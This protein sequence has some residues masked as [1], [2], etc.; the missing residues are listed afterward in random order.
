MSMWSTRKKPMRL[1]RPKM[2]IRF[3]FLTG[4]VSLFSI[5]HDLIATRSCCISHITWQT[6]IMIIS[7]FINCNIF[8]IIIIISSNCSMYHWHH[9]RPRPRTTCGALRQTPSN[10][11]SESKSYHSIKP[12]VA[13]RLV[14]CLVC[15]CVCPV[16]FCF[17]SE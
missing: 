16:V 14:S 17:E 15:V 4:R 5:S 10:E 6:Y 2:G 12:L 8:I 9:L 3:V 13:Y 1:E 7:I 11:E